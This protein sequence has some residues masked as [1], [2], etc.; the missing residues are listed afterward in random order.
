MSGGGGLR[1]ALAGCGRIAERGYV[2]AALETPGLRIV[3][4]ADPDRERLA[5]CREAWETAG[6]G[7][8]SGHADAAALLAAEEVDALVVA[9]P[10][11]THPEVAELA[12]AA[13][14]PCLVEKPPAADLDGALRLAALR[15]LPWL[16]FN[17]R[18]LQGEAL[19]PRVPAEGW[20]ELDLELRFRR[21]A[22]GAHEVRDEALLDAGI[23]MIDLARHLAGADPIS[24]R[25]AAVSP[26]RAALEIELARGRARVR[27]ATDRR[28]RES[29]QIRDRAGRTLARDVQGGVGGRLA[30]LRGAPHPLTLSLARQL[31]ALRDALRGPDGAGAGGDGPSGPAGTGEPGGAQGA[32]GPGAAPGAGALA[33]AV[34]GAVAMAVVEAARRS[35]AL[36]GAEVTVPPPDALSLRVSSPPWLQNAGGAADGAREGGGR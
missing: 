28:H 34:D 13:G 2:P 11:A 26:E 1:L 16:A 36:D 27:C 25:R 35:A 22:W 32:D 17:R 19:R 23:H 29:V 30:A 33:G 10:A 24:V 6:A 9:T 4:F 8:A 5:A 3:A 15:P 21:D 14:V 12:A 7:G 18:F 20:I 31:A